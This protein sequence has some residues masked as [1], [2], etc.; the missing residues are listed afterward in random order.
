M[1]QPVPKEVQGVSHSPERARVLVGNL[2]CQVVDGLG[3][4]VQGAGRRGAVHLLR[5]GHMDGVACPLPW[6]RADLHEVVLLGRQHVHEA[7]NQGLEPR[8]RRVDAGATSSDALAIEDNVCSISGGAEVRA[9]QF[10][11]VWLC[12]AAHS[13]PLRSIRSD[14]VGPHAVRLDVCG[15]AKDAVL[16][17][18]RRVQARALLPADDNVATALLATSQHPDGGQRGSGVL[19][20]QRGADGLVVCE[21]NHIVRANRLGH[22]EREEFVVGLHR[23][24]AHPSKLHVRRQAEVRA[25]DGHIHAPPCRD[26][27]KGVRR[28]LVHR[29]LGKV[30]EGEV[31]HNGRAAGRD[32]PHIGRPPRLALHCE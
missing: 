6:R 17:A 23:C 30:D 13:V 12:T 16:F 15:A 9:P 26:V 7:R 29:W 11:S 18:R 24:R 25:P 5:Q 10:H 28:A 32:A 19:Q 4:R 27:H 2:R 3:W 21:H 14:T 1:A 31:T 20:A 22:H 8:A